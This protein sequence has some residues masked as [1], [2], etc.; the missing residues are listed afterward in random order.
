MK[1]WHKPLVMSL[2]LLLAVYCGRSQVG[3]DKYNSKI[4]PETTKI[5][6]PNTGVTLSITKGAA[7]GTTVAFSP[8]T[9][10]IDTSVFVEVV[11]MP[12][13]FNVSNVTRS[14]PAISVGASG[15]GSSV[16]TLSSPL[17]ISVPVDTL[18]LTGLDLTARSTENLC[19]FLKSGSELFYWRKSALTLHASE[20]KNFAKVLSNRLGI[21][22]LVYCGNEPLPGF[23]DASQAKL[24]VGKEHKITFDAALYGMSQAKLCIG[25]VSGSKKPN[26]ADESPE[27]S[28]GGKSVAINGSGKVTVSLNFDNSKLVTGGWAALVFALLQETDTCGIETPGQLA[29]GSLKSRGI[30]AWGIQYGDLNSGLDG[31][32]GD[33][34]YALLP[35]RATLKEFSDPSTPPGA[36]PAGTHCLT[37]DA[38]LDSEL[39][40]AEFE[41]TTTAG[42]LSQNYSFPL[43]KATS[44]KSRLQVGSSCGADSS[45]TSSATS[46]DIDFPNAAQPNLTIASM[47]LSTSLDNTYCVNIYESSAFSAANTASVTATPNVAW[48]N[49]PLGTT[50]TSFIIPYL[51]GIYDMSVQLACM[52]TNI[53]LNDQRYSTSQ[54]IDPPITIVP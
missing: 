19:M 34:K 47:T 17:A 46:Y 8:G 54:T 6:D 48:K 50:G 33:A 4:P 14:S 32:F 42:N 10:E 52:G 22:Q 9:L 36:L 44:Y 28:L 24:S 30:Y 15:G 35:A 11:S 27:F 51:T 23:V 49:V 1:S 53:Y 7:S 2:T 20:G 45:G 31:E 43:P 16:T 5:T 26:G 38:S 41:V 29:N 3:N 25:V 13:D 12:A 21:F 18:S 40:H 37:F 39:A